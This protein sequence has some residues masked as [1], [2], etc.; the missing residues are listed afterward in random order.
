[1]QA[2]YSKNGRIWINYVFDQILQ[3]S[4]NKK[5]KDP[6][7]VLYKLLQNAPYLTCLKGK[8]GKYN[9]FVWEWLEKKLGTEKLCKPANSFSQNPFLK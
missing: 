9:L 5:R 4:F 3:Y 7:F 6:E 1:M 8:M 2:C